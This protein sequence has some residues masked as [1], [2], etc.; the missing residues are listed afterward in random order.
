MSS[1]DEKDRIATNDLATTS[2]GSSEQGLKEAIPEVL[3]GQKK[4][5]LGS[6]KALSGWLVVNFAVSQVAVHRADQLEQRNADIILQTGP[7]SSMLFTILPASIQTVANAVGHVPGSTEPCAPMG[8]I[9]CV[10][11]FGS[12]EVDYLTYL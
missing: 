12:R 7:T 11:R 10:V 5:L 2:H 1:Y 4:G 3:E 8:P 6:S 9:V